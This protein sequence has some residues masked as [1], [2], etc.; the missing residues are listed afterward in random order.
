MSA[1]PL[2]LAIL[3]SLA[4]DVAGDSAS[5]GAPT[6]SLPRLAK[7]LG[8]SASVLLRELALMGDAALGGVPGP[9]WVQVAQ[10]GG[11]WRVQLT[12]VGLQRAL[13]QP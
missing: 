9:G 2:A 12:P 4:Q 8:L 7:R 10:H 11:Q 5:H 6:M 13:Q 1:S 3:R